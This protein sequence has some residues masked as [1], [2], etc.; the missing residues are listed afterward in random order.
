MGVDDEARR[1]LVKGQVPFLDVLL[2]AVAGG[3]GG[4][5]PTPARG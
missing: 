1:K 3:A 4:G 2:E 5:W